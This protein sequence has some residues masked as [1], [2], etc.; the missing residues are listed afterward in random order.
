MHARF[1]TQFH[2][3]VARHA[4]FHILYLQNGN[5]GEN[6]K[7]QQAATATARRL[8]CR[9]MLCPR[10]SCHL[11]Y[12]CVRIYYTNRREVPA[13]AK[14]CVVP[15]KRTR[16]RCIIIFRDYSSVECSL[17]CVKLKKEKMHEKINSIYHS[18]IN[19]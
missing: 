3:R 15:V 13:G 1:I 18:C 17:F 6:N 10:V 16:L 8:C 11:F 4:Y 9:V 14:R 19:V 12:V 2:V 7:K 5:D